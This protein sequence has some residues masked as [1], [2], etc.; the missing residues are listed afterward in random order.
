[1]T[2]CDLEGLTMLQQRVTF[3]FRSSGLLEGR[4]GEPLAR[5]PGL[6]LWFD[7]EVWGISGICFEHGKTSEHFTFTGGT[8][9]LNQSAEP[10]V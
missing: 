3:P 2:S 1:M 9:E 8:N 6:V 7:L 4:F 5:V 10:G